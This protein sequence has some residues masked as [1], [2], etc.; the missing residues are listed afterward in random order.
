MNQV[1]IVTGGARGIGRACAL[2]LARKGFDIGLVDL[3]DSEMAATAAD[4]RALG[5][6]VRTYQADVAVHD[7]A[8]EIVRDVHSA[9]GRIDFLLNNAGQ[10]QPKG[11]LETSEEEFDRGIAINLKS[12]FNYIHHAAPLM[13]EQGGGRIVS[14]S[15]LNALSGGVTAAVSKFAYAA[16][17]AGILGMTRALAKELGPTIAINAICPGVILT[18][19]GTDVTAREA[20]IVKGIALGR[21]G[22]ADDVAR[23][24]TFLATSEPCFITGQT[25]V[26][27]GFQ[28]NV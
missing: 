22:C 9:F 14:M 16:A 7:R 13:L 18:E 21:L 12:C 1:A 15:S 5:R 2:D 24:V 11:I 26:V 19:I 10:S 25:F 17:K 4:I 3:L 28:F 8:G 6:D 27:D 23:L 20:E